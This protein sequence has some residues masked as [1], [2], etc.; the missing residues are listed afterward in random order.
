MTYK[1]RGKELGG[2]HM[3]KGCEKQLIY[4]LFIF[5]ESGGNYHE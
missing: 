5:I 1:K 3:E 4:Q 2:V